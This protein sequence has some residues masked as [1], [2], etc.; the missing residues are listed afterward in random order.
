MKKYLFLLLLF[1][2]KPLIFP[3]LFATIDTSWVRRY[4]N[5]SVNDSD[6]ARA[7]AVDNSGNVCVAGVSRR[8]NSSYDI[9]T[10]KYQPNGAVAWFDR[11]STG[12]DTTAAIAGI[13]VDG[14]G[15]VY[16]AGNRKKSGS[17]DYVT[18]KYNSSGTRLWSAIYNGPDN[19]DDIANAIAV[20]VSGN[21]YV[22]GGSKSASSNYDFLTVKY[23]ASGNQVWAKRSDMP[24]NQEDIATAIALRKDTVYVTG[25]SYSSTASYDYYTFKYD[26]S[27]SVIWYKNYN[28]TG[29]GDD[30]PSSIAVDAS[31]SVYVTGLSY[32]SGTVNDYATIKYRADGTQP[33]ASRYNGITGGVD[34][35]TAMALDGLGNIYVTGQ[36]A[37]SGINYDYATVKYNTNGAQQWVTRYNGLGNGDDIA[38]AIAVNSS[39]QV[40]VTGW[41][42]GSGTGFDYTTIKYNSD[43]TLL[44]IDR[45]LASTSQDDKAAA[46]AIRG[47]TAYVTGGSYNTTSSMDYLTVKYRPVY[48]IGITMITQPNGIVD[49]SATI[50]PKAK[51]KNNGSDIINFNTTFKIGTY[52]SLKTINN[53]FPSKETTITFDAWTIGPRNNYVSKCSVALVSDE[54]RTNDTLSCAFSIR[55]RDYAATSITAPTSPADS[56]TVITPKAWIYNNGTVNEADSVKFYIVGTSYVSMKYVILNAGNSIE[57]SFDPF[58]LNIPRGSYTMRCTTKL[59]SDMVVSNNL[60]TGIFSMRVHDYAAVTITSPASPVDSG[61]IITPTV[62]I[63]NNGT[64]DETDVPVTFYII[65]T[66]YTST[67]LVTLSSG[68]SVEQSFD[69]F[70]LNIPRGSYTMR[71]TTNL[72]SDMVVSNNLATGIFSMRV[73]DYAAVTITSPASPVDSGT[74]ITP[75]VWI[76]NNGT[77]DETNI[78]VTMYIVGT[79]YTSTQLVTLSSGRSV[80]QSFDPFTLNIPRGSYTMRCTTKLNSDMVVSNNLAIGL[81]DVQ[82]HD[83]ATGGI[84]S[85]VG[86]VDS[87]STIMPSAKIVNNGTT[88]E[89]DI[90]VTF[91]IVGTSYSSTKLVSLNHG[92]SVVQEFDD[93]VVNIPRGT[94][95]MRCTTKL[96]NDLVVV[97]N[98]ATS[99]LEMRVADVGVTEIIKPNGDVDSTSAITLRAKVKNFGTHEA[100]FNVTISIG[101]WSSTKEVSALIPDNDE[102]VSFDKPWPVGYRGNYT[103]KCSTELNDDMVTNNDKLEGSFNVIVRDYAT[104][105]ITA[106]LAPVYC[107][108][109][110]IPKAWIY[111]YGTQAETDVPV[112]F[113]VQ[114][115]SYSSTKNVTLG[116][117]ASIEQSFDTLFVNFADGVYLMRCTTKLNNDTR[118]DNNLTWDSLYTRV[119]GWFKLRDISAI[120]AR[121]GISDGGA[122]TVTGNSIYALQGGNTRYFYAYQADHDTWITVCSIPKARKPDGKIINKNVRDGAALVSKDNIIYAFKG[123]GTNEFWAY[124]P[125]RDSWAQKHSIL[126]YAIGSTRKTYIKTGGALVNAVDSIY[127]FKGGSTNEFWVYDISL[128][129]WYYRKPLIVY[130]ATNKK[131]KTGAT[132]VA[133]GCTVYAFVGGATNYFYMYLCGMDTWIR[134]AD[135][136]FGCLRTLVRPLKDGASMVNKD[137]I[138]YALK[139][140]N[141][142]DFGYYN[143]TKDSW[144][145][146]D[147]IAVSGRTGVKLGGDLVLVGPRIYAVQGGKSRQFFRYTPSIRLPMNEVISLIN[148][149]ISAEVVDDLIKPKFNINPNPFTNFATIRFNVL[150]P[151]NISISLY[152]IDGRQIRTVLNR[153]YERGSYSIKLNAK[154]FAKGVYFLKY[155]DN[156]NSKQLKLIIN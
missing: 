89:T 5:S 142:K 35:A 54:V 60:A 148:P 25:Y 52:S 156:K 57:Q 92:E 29:N 73:H 46:I 70:T 44:W 31:G 104:T 13:V 63:Y 45:S 152:S 64:T 15:N 16:V 7:I 38:T 126:E 26:P 56:G 105:A 115:T 24:A 49:S 147:T 133:K 4:N 91:Y 117:G 53:L 39:N 42:A 85:P 98:L 153:Y 97:N 116:S 125:N 37:G 81:F 87:L 96:V 61:T 48:D 124:F 62:W 78:P 107:G 19:L 10:I 80:E 112:T 8:N 69:P 127:A 36:S 58:T 150:V 123:N 88:D 86:L 111:N 32:G 68:R 55:V 110:I 3:S 14:S 93:F 33:W 83:Y 141:T 30:K 120:P 106:P 137:G 20:D 71:C 43:S 121:S 11:F 75:T 129:T 143:P 109:T 27:G 119:I 34:M 146:L 122:L 140:N 134:K 47:D 103:V 41:S 6:Y 77:T 18:L 132:L 76:Y 65:G 22:T 50:N 138:I 154:D 72:N 131:I 151:S 144:Y 130:G 74:I 90:P 135:V 67:Q 23:D 51:I 113:Y 79:S 136:R 40:F 149:T 155:N 128:D 84:V 9:Y 2:V 21:V 114:G 82:I 66:S 59:N 108:D 101:S 145:T 28:G 17:S 99:P 139:G 1:V 95:T 12:S 94:Y 100:T 118:A 102:E